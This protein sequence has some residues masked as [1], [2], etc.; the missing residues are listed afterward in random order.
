MEII[1]MNNCKKSIAFIEMINF[2]I[3][4]PNKRAN[5]YHFTAIIFNLKLLRLIINEISPW[6]H[7]LIDLKVIF[8]D[9]LYL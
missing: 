9:F 4:H 3:A 5:S 1:F 2:I 6:L 8:H 7:V